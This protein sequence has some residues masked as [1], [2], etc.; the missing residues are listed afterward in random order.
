MLD[1]GAFSA[2][3]Q[4]K[5]VILDEY[6]KF[7]KENEQ[8]F[9]TVVNLDVINP[10]DPDVAAEA[11][12]KNFWEMRDKGINCMPVFHARESRKWLD[13]YIDS[14]DYV[15]LSGT[16]L[17]S[18]VEDKSWH[19]IIWSY[20]TDKDGYPIIKTHSFGNTSEY[21]ALTMPWTTL[22]SAT[23][24]IQAGRAARVKLQGKSYQLRSNK[25]GK[26]DTNFISIHDTGLKREAWEAEFREL[27][28]NPD[29]IMN[30]KAKGSEL[31]MMRSYL[32]ASDL[33]KLQ[34]Q[35]RHV[36]KF[37]RPASLITTKRQQE[38]GFEREGTAT[39]V[40]V[41]SPSAY[42]F[43]YPVLRALGINNLLVSYYY[44]ATASKG[45]WE[46]KLIPFL[47]DPDDFLER[48]PQARKFRDKLSEVLL[49]PA[50]E[51]VSV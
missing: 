2:F 34:E 30:V 29:A 32:V 42:Y 3:T 35:T 47:L 49:K 9:T 11:G 16:S 4:G 36:T 43:N 27:G 39:F 17:V 5:P 20:I 31:A 28:I 12:M 15:G 44:V 40:F 21:M 10:Q 45:F 8:Y 25:I 41:I 38:G 50:A 19:R 37:F 24:M 51:A 6:C 48:D 33:M 1:S 22:D 14:T 18:P 46:N 26:N 23:W 13:Q 7:V